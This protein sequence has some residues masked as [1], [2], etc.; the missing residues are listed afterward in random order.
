MLEDVTP[1]FWHGYASSTS[2]FVFL[3]LKSLDELDLFLSVFAAHHC[4][5][6]VLVTTFGQEVQHEL[7]ILPDAIANIGRIHACLAKGGTSAA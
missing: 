1:K 4:R 5:G 7:A 6:L 2:V 3:L